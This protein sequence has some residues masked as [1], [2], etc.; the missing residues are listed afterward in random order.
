MLWDTLE[1]DLRRMV[2]GVIVSKN[3][4]FVHCGKEWH[5]LGGLWQRMLFVGGDSV[6][7]EHTLLAKIWDT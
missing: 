5:F 3:G 6:N 4:I 2:F 7:F 1:T